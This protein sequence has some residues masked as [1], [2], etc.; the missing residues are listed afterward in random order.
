MEAGRMVPPVMALL[1]YCS[2][3]HQLSVSRG[4]HHWTMFL[5]KDRTFWYPDIGHLEEPKFDLNGAKKPFSAC[6]G[7]SQEFVET[8]HP[9]I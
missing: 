6:G 8:H 4:Q 3:V 2:S 1:V 7:F 5:F 9:P